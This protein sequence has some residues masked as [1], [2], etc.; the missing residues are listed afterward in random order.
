MLTKRTAPD[1]LTAPRHTFGWPTTEG[2]PFQ[3][4]DGHCR[5]LQVRYLASFFGLHRCVFVI[6]SPTSVGVELGSGDA[7]TDFIG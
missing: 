5:T 6:W 3:V 4:A 2:R 7:C 1:H